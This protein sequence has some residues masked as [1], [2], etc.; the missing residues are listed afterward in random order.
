MYNLCIFYLQGK[1]DCFVSFFLTHLLNFILSIRL[2]MKTTGLKIPMYIP[3]YAVAALA[4]AI[5]GGGY[6]ENA[7]GM[8]LSYLTILGCL[9]FLFRVIHREDL[10]WI[11]GLIGKS[12][13]RH[14]PV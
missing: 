2:L 1:A 5:M 14:Q 12:P 11:L 4:L 10:S 3:L 6:V 9:L 8:V 13:A 7:P